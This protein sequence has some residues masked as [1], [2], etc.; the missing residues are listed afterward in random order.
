MR[1]ALVETLISLAKQDPRIVLLTGDLGYTVIEPF[2][3]QYPDRFYNIGVAE[4]NMVGIATGLAE[5]GYIPFVYSIVTFATLRPYE[6]IR[7]GPILHNLPVRIVGVGGGVEYGP[8][9]PTHHGLEDVAVFR[10]YP[11]M[12][13]FTPA[14]ARQL[15]STLSQCWDRPG[16]AYYRVGKFENLEVP[17]LDGN[18]ELGKLNTVTRGSDVLLLSMGSIS[19]ETVDAAIKLTREGINAQVSVVSQ[20][21]PFPI[22]ALRNELKK[23][24]LVCTIEGHLVTGGLGSAVAE[25][26]SESS[27]SCTLKR[28]GIQDMGTERTGGYEYLIHRSG[29]DSDSLCKQIHSWL[30]QYK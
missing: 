4:Q 27:L 12:E 2:Q 10:H 20:I 21:N 8:A 16:P 19:T 25:I 29:L 14:D 23:F 22:E 3:E 9:G 18:F 5:A 26:L 1:K 24:S 15:R 30:S 17:G 11:N 6:F 7:N 13:I 28:F